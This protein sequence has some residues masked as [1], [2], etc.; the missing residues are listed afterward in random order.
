MN[1]NIVLPTVGAKGYFKLSA[2]FNSDILEGQPYTCRSVRTID[3][4]FS[5][6]ESPKETIYAPKGLPDLEFDQ[7]FQEGNP[8]VGLETDG[9]HWVYVPSRYISGFPDV[10][11]VAY[12]GLSLVVSLPALPVSRDLTSLKADIAAVVTNHLGIAPLVNE[13]IT[14]KPVLVPVDDHVVLMAQREATRLSSVDSIATMEFLR[15]QNAILA[16]QVQTLTAYLTSL[17]S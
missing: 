12:H 1:E 3:E 13:V 14:S 10:S 9:G 4:Y 17:A 6:G 15:Q 7:D 5:N 2:P 11:G 8:I 16:Q